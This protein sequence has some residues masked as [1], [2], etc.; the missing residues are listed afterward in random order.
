MKG[1]VLILTL[2][3]QEWSNN[4]ESVSQDMHISLHSI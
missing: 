1:M 3:L 4:S 2:I